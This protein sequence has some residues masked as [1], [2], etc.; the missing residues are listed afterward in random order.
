VCQV[1]LGCHRLAWFLHLEGYKVSV[2]LPNKS[3]HYLKSLGFKS[4]TDKIDTKGLATMA[5]Q[6]SL[7]VW[8]PLSPQIYELRQLTRHYQQLQESRVAFQNQL[9]AHLFGR[10]KN[11]LVTTH[12]QSLIS[13]L[14]QQLK[15]T[16][17][18]IE[19]CLKKDPVLW[20]KVQSINSIK[21]LGI[22]S[23]ATVIAETDG[24][25]LFKNLSQVVCYSGYDVI[26]NQSGTHRGKTRIS[27]KGN[28]RIRR[29]L[30]MPAFC[31]VK[32]QVYPFLELY[33]RVYDRTRTKMK[34][35]TAVQRKLLIL[36]YTLWKKNEPFRY[37][38]ALTVVSGDDG[39][40]ALFP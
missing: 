19:D 10:Q 20:E 8:S 36:I 26:E 21:G 18:A 32:L 38:T 30:F 22:I 27:K 11:E 1:G 6:Q 35:Y 28:K 39:S 14:E 40:D 16:V 34:A 37:S 3:K 17:K 33:E 23:I 5:V 7:S 25:H 15:T 9:H 31:V 13:S 2:V 12:L 4:K 24:F 29:I